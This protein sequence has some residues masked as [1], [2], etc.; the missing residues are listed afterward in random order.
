[1]DR[2]IDGDTAWIR[3]RVRLTR[4]APDRGPDA[5]VATSALR[6]KWPRGSRVQLSI[7]AVDSYG[8]VIGDL[9][10][11]TFVEPT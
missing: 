2:V 10:P 6:A 5:V 9:Y 1:V 11:D 8:R 4:S 3:V 7:N